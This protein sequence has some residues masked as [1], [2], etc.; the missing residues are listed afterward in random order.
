VSRARWTAA[1]LLL[2]AAAPAAAQDAAWSSFVVRIGADT[3]AV[4]GYARTPALLEGTLTG[5]SVGR[6]AYR[7][8]L[9]AGAATRSLTLHAWRPG[10]SED[11]AAGQV[12]RLEQLGD[13]AVVRIATPAGEQRQR[14]DTREGSILYVNPSFALT[15]QIVLRARAVGGDTVE[16]P[17][18][19]LQGG[20]TV[21]ATVVRMGA[22]SAAIRIAGS[23]MRVAVAADGRLLGGAI[24]AQSLTFQRVEGRVSFA[25]AMRPP[26]YSAP[27]GA[28][29]T[30]E[31]VVVTTPAGHT[32]AGTLTRPAGLGPFPAAVTITGSGPQDRDQ[33]IPVVPRYRPMRD[34]AD[35]LAR[36]G[37]AVLRL[38][39]RGTGGS[40]GDFSAATSADFADDVRAAL[41]YL[42]ARP[43][44][45]P[46]RLALVGHSEGG[47]I[48][49]LVAADDPAL[50]AVVAIAGPAR[51]GREIIHYQQRFA[52]EG[53]PGLT[54]A[55][56]DSAI[57]A[58]RVEMEEAAARQ[59]WL[60]FFLD[61]DPLP[62]ARRVRV[63]VLVLQ[64]ETDR[65]VTAEQ[66]ELLAAAVREGGN[67]D[68]TVRL[69]PGI[70][71]L[72][73]RDPDGSP[74]GYS[75]LPDRRVAPE[76]LGALADW[77]AERLR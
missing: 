23:E 54:A 74:A 77:L 70:N 51:T 58:A 9:G 41:A 28:P 16:V 17:V 2:A 71:H 66:A 73:L 29:Y 69:F 4:E 20:R 8:E 30:A 34:I 57:A 43:D 35:T 65:Q 60:D 48:G 45:D 11:S 64:G 52:I 32:L 10:A 63:P 15:E 27:A 68:V 31:E 56:R 25:G 55:G 3:F 5:H 53:L 14:L 21:P 46:A 26:D 22:D 13:S 67:R 36:R 61:H 59:P 19:L 24:P 6:L 7:V 50:G 40:G 72:L 76:V 38:D 12:V 1:A 37:I 42:R 49:P 33:A 44:V 47:L 62:V 75:A 39:D 18:L